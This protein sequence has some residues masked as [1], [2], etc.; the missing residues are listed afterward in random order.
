MQALDKTKVAQEAN[1]IKLE[2]YQQIA[3]Q[4]YSKG[5]KLRKFQIEEYVL[6]KVFQNTKNSIQK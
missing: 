5:V 4:H 2:K 6:R 1:V 3:A